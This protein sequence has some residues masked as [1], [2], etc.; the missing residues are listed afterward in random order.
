[1]I[2]IENYAKM[3]FMA[4]EDVLEFSRN[5]RTL[6]GIKVNFES[7]DVLRTGIGMC[8]S[9]LLALDLA[10]AKDPSA[11]LLR[12]DSAIAVDRFDPSLSSADDLGL[13]IFLARARKFSKACLHAIAAAARASFPGAAKFSFGVPSLAVFP[14]DDLADQD[15]PLR[16]GRTL[17]GYAKLRETL[18]IRLKLQERKFRGWSGE[19]RQKN[20]QRRLSRRSQTRP[21]KTPETPSDSEDD[22]AGKEEFVLQIKRNSDDELL[23]AVKEEAVRS[24]EEEPPRA[25]E[26]E[27]ERKWT[28]V[29]RGKRELS[30][31]FSEDRPDSDPLQRFLRQ[32][33]P[34]DRDRVDA[35][36]PIAKLEHPEPKDRDRVDS[37]LPIAKLEYPE[38]KKEEPLDALSRPQR[39]N[40]P[41]PPYLRKLE[42]DYF[43]AMAEYQAKRIHVGPKPSPEVLVVDD[44]PADEIAE[45]PKKNGHFSKPIHLAKRTQPPNEKN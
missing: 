42:E 13:F 14:R 15:S 16:F 29:H 5:S 2:C 28:G 34:K 41:L 43:S 8:R 26:P 20:K 3:R 11:K 27:K 22:C 40:S 24:K 25:V 17:P 39:R 33:K 4:L 10:A 30:W 44:L 6:L 19:R 35:L 18:A 21:P 23:V 32:L 7:D 1:M 38:P 31:K 36:P 45:I 9:F 37:L 12:F